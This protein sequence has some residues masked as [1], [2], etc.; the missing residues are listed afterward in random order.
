MLDTLNEEYSEVTMPDQNTE[1]AKQA[2][3]AAEDACCTDDSCDCD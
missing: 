1:A 3:V 2:E